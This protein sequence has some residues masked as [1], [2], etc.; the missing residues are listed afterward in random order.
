MAEVSN[1]FILKSHENERRNCS[2]MTLLFSA[3]VQVKELKVGKKGR[4]SL[5][6]FGV[7]NKKFQDFSIISFSEINFRAF[8][9]VVKAALLK[10]ILRLEVLLLWIQEILKWPRKSAMMILT[11]M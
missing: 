5:S 11:I 9:K 7:I 8:P 6:R 4:E 1:T 3:L 10:I 2:V